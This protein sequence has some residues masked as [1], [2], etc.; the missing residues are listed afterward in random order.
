MS[1]Q[2]RRYGGGGAGGR[3]PPNGCLCPHFGSLKML[4]LEHHATTRQQPMMEKGIIT[5]KQTLKQSLQRID[6]RILKLKYLVRL[7]LSGNSIKIFLR[8]YGA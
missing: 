1:I 4:F 7:N 5:F 8:L 3:A 2:S 6:S